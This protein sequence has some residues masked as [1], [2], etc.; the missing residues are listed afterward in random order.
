M[1]AKNAPLSNFHDTVLS[2]LNKH[3]PKKMKYIRSN[4]CNFMTKESRK[5]IMNRSKVRNK[6]L[7]TRSRNLEGVLIAKEN[8]GLAFSAKLKYVFFGKVD[9]KVFSDNTKFWKTVS[10]LFLERGFHKEFILLNNNNKTISNNEELAE[11]FNK[12]FSKLIE[13]VDIDETLAS[14]IASSDMTDPVSDAIKKYEDHPSIKKS[15]IS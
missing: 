2:V 7:K 12:H 13:N 4:N 6:F 3:A 10:P 8:S 14:N 9:H 11:T 15:N 5:A 1:I